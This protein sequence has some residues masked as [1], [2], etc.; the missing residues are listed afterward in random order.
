M[1]IKLTPEE[2]LF[3]TDKIENDDYGA[4]EQECDPFELLRKFAGAYRSVATALLQHQED[5]MPSEYLLDLTEPELWV[6]RGKVS[7]LDGHAQNPRFGMRLLN[8]I[9]QALLNPAVDRGWLERHTDTVGGT[10]GTGIDVK[11]AMDQWKKETGYAAN[12]TED[13]A[14]LNEA[15][16]QTFPG[17]AGLPGARPDPQS[18]AQSHAQPWPSTGTGQDLSRPEAEDCTAD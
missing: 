6:L 15:D 14:T 1:I 8:K 3:L 9:Y 2:V 10:H 18:H 12:T 11:A 7:S 17:E 5:Q 16:D 13:E 4:E